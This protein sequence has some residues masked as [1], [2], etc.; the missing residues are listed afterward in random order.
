MIGFKQIG[1]CG[2][3]GNQMFQFASTV[4]VANKVGHSVAFPVENITVP[5]VEHFKD[6]V[7]REVYF[8]LPKYFPNV[9]RTLVPLKLCFLHF[10]KL[11]LE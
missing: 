4:G 6:G 8:D 9:I 10:Q 11:G 1:R 2:R 7:R 5:S 3:F